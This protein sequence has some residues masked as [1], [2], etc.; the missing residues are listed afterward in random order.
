M[1]R[2][3][4]SGFFQNIVS[5]D[6]SKTLSLEIL[7]S[8]RDLLKGALQNHKAVIKQKRKFCIQKREFEGKN[9]LDL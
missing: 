8:E 1:G 6:E 9:Y 2:T 7:L 3:K 5:A 4:L